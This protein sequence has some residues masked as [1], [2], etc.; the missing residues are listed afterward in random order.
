MTDDTKMEDMEKLFFRIW[1]LR[2]PGLVLSL[3]G[4][5]P[6]AKALQKRC[7]NLIFGVF[8]KTRKSAIEHNPFLFQRGDFKTRPSM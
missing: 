2:K 8:R 6:S 7:Y 3:H 1:R 4:S 5:I